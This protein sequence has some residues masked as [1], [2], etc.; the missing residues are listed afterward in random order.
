MRT[1]HRRGGRGA[2]G[3]DAGH[4]DGTRGTLTGPSAA[5]RLLR[6]L[7]PTTVG[8]WGVSSAFST[9]TRTAPRP[10]R[11]CIGPTVRPAPATSDATESAVAT[12][13]FTC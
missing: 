8:R 1:V 10:P 6:P 13:A 12:K 11:R 3:R 7:A 2:P 4:P 9:R 5:A